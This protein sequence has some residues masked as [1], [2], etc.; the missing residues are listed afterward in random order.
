VWGGQ[1][2]YSVLH[3][4][5]LL[6]VG[7]VAASVV[8]V[9][10]QQFCVGGPATVFCA[11]FRLGVRRVATAFVAVRGQHLCVGWPATALYATVAGC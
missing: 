1:L 9:W 5:Q 6:G 3:M 7:G 11:A 4:L 2:L 8:A 10:G